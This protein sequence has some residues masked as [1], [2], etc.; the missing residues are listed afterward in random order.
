MD[1]FGGWTILKR[2][3]GG[4]QSDVDLVRSPHHTEARLKAVN[5]IQDALRYSPIQ[6]SPG[7]V[8]KLLEGIAAATRLD[9]DANLGAMKR[10]K[11]P[12]AGPE[13]A[14]A[15][16]RLTNEISVLEENRPGH[17]RLLDHDIRGRW[18]VTEY[19]PE[20][21]LERQIG[22]YHGKTLLALKAFRSV[23]NTVA[24]LHSSGYVH[25]DIKP[26][27][28]FVR[29]DDQLVLGDFGIVF[30][31]NQD[32]R[33]THTNERVGPRD[34]MPH[35][36]HRG[37][38]LDK[39]SSSFDVYMLGKLLWCMLSG[40]LF[41]PREDFTEAD[42]DLQLMFPHLP[43]MKTI[44]SLL[45]LCLVQKEADCLRSAREL[46]AAL[47]E[48]IREVE[49]EPLQSLMREGSL[50]LDS[51]KLRFRCS[52]CGRGEYV[53]RKEIFLVRAV[54]DQNMPLNDVRLNVFSCN[55][56]THYQLFAPGYP[57]EALSRDWRPLFDANA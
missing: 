53:R 49:Q 50:T 22:K 47:D 42:C 43:E 41:L 34:Y 55:V 51:G 18:L 29:S 57:Q 2:I 10:F 26:A 13:Q 7:A 6:Q 54:T 30:L 38:R 14:E 52:A 44:N 8:D 27:N 4:G 32:L 45:G 1:Q 37:T 31:P 48:T 40:R 16:M 5:M 35:W 24:S 56:C 20:G 12:D 17:P 3:G 19:F 23:A 33:L 25:R 46:L 21:S 15:V 11:I 36:A 28:I 39:V 9:Q